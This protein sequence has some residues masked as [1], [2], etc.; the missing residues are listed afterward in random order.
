MQSSWKVTKFL[1]IYPRKYGYKIQNTEVKS[2]VISSPALVY[3]I[4]RPITN[5]NQGERQHSLLTKTEIFSITS[6][7]WKQ[8][9][10]VLG[11]E[12]FVAVMAGA[13]PVSLTADA[14]DS[15]FKSH[16]F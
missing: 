8:S 9:P 11:L 3:A 6:S 16:Y 4:D 15:H 5:E 1:T 14:S 13:S 12:P 7:I 10:S 2:T